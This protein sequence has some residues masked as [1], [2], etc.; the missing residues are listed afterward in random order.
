MHAM[1]TSVPVSLPRCPPCLR[2]GV[3]VNETLNAFEAVNICH[4][5]KQ[6]RE[7]AS[8]LVALAYF[9]PVRPGTPS[10]HLPLH[11]PKHKRNVRRSRLDNK[12][13]C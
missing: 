2:H 9:A 7:D 10:V 6:C 11:V 5:R 1:M 4:L 8:S 12:V 13:T 3:V